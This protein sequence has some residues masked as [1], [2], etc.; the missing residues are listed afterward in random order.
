LEH[1]SNANFLSFDADLLKRETKCHLPTNGG[2][3]S[4]DICHSPA[5]DDDE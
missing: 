5:A 1:R 2:G 3:G 4:G